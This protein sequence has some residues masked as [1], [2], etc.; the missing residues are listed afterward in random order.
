MGGR[1]WM[2]SEPG[3]GSTFHFTLSLDVAAESEPALPAPA[4]ALVRPSHTSAPAAPLAGD[5]VQTPRR[6][7]LVEDN[8]VNQRV[9]SGLLTRRGHHVTVAENGA[10]ALDRLE[11][12]RFDAV[13]MDVQMPVMGGLEATAAIR[14]RE[15]GTGR[16]VR[17][18]A[19][20][21]H[22]MKG[23]RER[24]LES[25]MDGYLTKPLQ[26]ERL[27]AAVEQPDTGLDALATEAVAPATIFNQRI[28]LER[29]S[30]DRTLLADVVQVFLEDCPVR[31]AAIETAVA[32]RD[33]EALN[34]ATHALKGAAASL[35][36]DRLAAAAGVLERLSKDKRLDAADAA[37]R[38]LAVEARRLLDALAALRLEWTGSTPEREASMRHPARGDRGAAA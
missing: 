35:A 30:G 21:A 34:A 9:A 14:T 38:E 36:A 32:A 17:I 24:C 29:L 8:V 11:R 33:P 23:D 4:P 5:G 3:V 19:M 15:L 6:L 37:W 26:P 31:L 28:L 2:E 20:T 1:L 10:V 18:V 12:E 22:A 27:F 16:H 7:L 13:L 25:G